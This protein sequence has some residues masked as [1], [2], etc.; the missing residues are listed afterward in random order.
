MSH[1]AG[2]ARMLREINEAAAL[3]HLLDGGPLTRGDLCALTGL[4]KP[5]IS[6]AVRRLEEAGLV[7]VVGRTSGG[8][9]PNADVYGVNP[10]AAYGA[11]VSLRARDSTLVTALC[12]LTGEVRARV[13]TPVD[14]AAT[15]P[16]DAIADVVAAACK[17]ARVAVRRVVHVQLGVPG[18][19]H[20][21]AGV[22]RYVDVPGWSRP[23]LVE[24]IRARLRTGLS[25]DNDV[26]LAAVAER[27]HGIAED[28]EGF[29]L[30]W[31]GEEGLG[32]A[33]DLGGSLLRGARGGAGEIGYMPVGLPAEGT[34]HDFHD[35]VSGQAVHE[36]AARH[37][38]AADTGYAAVAAAVEAGARAFIDELALR[39]AVGLAAV[40]A[41]LDPP[42]VVLAGEVGHAGGA[43]LH[44]AVGA[45]LREL[46][47]LDTAVASTGVT[48]DP[49]LLGAMN[50]TLTAVRTALL[51]R[52]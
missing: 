30:L 32:L 4:A 28:V 40:I 27:S 8:R 9:G 33:I 46:S 26:N 47:V 12:D 25:V 29:A 48:E 50:T 2:S 18:S 11:A 19:Y 13:E 34:V 20:E 44:K 15:D 49:V 17:Q 39:I 1:Q 21:N 36:L 7:K 31:L 10:N 23:G 3:G 24:E 6:E 42:L 52:G 41:V 16:V 45:A 5:T 43:E 51:D 14:F 37:G 35:L 38:I 22:I